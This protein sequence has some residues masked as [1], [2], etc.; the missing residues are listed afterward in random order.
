MKKNSTTSVMWLLALIFLSN[1]ASAQFTFSGEIR[2]RTEYLH[3]FGSLA[4]DSQDPAFWTEQRSRLKFDYNAS[5]YQFGLVVQDIRVWGSVPQL[6]KTDNLS[7]IHEAW[8][9]IL[10]NQN[11]SL[12]L[13][14]QE[15]IYDD[16]RIFGNVGWAQQAR[17]HDLARL[18]YKKNTFAFDLGLAFN[19]DGTK[20]TDNIYTIAN[21]YKS[22]QYLW[23]HKDFN[24][25]GASVLILNNGRQF[26]EQGSNGNIEYSTVFS[27][28]IGT[29]LTYKKEKFNA[30]GSFYSQTGK[31]AG[32]NDLSAYDIKAEL[33]YS[34]TDKF[35]LGLGYELL[36]G[37]SEL[38]TTA[39]E[40]NSFAPLY[41]TNHKFNGFMD[42]FYVGNHANS[43][44]LQDIYARLKYKHNKKF[45]AVAD[46]HLFSA[47]ADVLDDAEVLNSGNYEAMNTS[48]GTEID[49]TLKYMY[50]KELFFQA[51]YSHLLATET[52]EALKGGDKDQT[53]NWAYL[54]ITFRPT[55]YKK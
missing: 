21:S 39:T 14:R 52:M 48:L 47:A 26:S 19:Q 5:K 37:T 2:P 7:S 1:F 3:G 15:V 46:V 55:F 32:N 4:E 20:R 53:N 31:D 24:S 25:F 10:F 38:D 6:N 49:I 42:Y 41:G 44:G 12:K 13:G 35:G 45:S 29:H 50:S 51:G 18:Q 9:A 34:L 27:Q 23:L 40:N 22:L 33:N 36:S 30:V 54:M 11:W 43:V 28:T 8:G 17:S 16:H